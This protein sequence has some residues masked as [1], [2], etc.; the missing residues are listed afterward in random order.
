ME[1]VY[2]SCIKSIKIVRTLYLQVIKCAGPG[3]DEKG[4][5][6]EKRV[7]FAVVVPRFFVSPASLP[8]IGVYFYGGVHPD[9]QLWL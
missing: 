5:P 4:F 3:A 8:A 2:I 7:F 9:R 1:K 6:Y